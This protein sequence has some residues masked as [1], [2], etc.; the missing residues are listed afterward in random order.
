MGGYG[1]L[2]PFPKHE[3]RRA[4]LTTISKCSNVT[5]NSPFLR[6]AMLSTK[7]GATSVTKVVVKRSL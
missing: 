4:A 2:F 1:I 6:E 7:I 5:W 3:E